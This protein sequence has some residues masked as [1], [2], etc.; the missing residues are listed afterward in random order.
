MRDARLALGRL[1]ALRK[2][3]DEAQMWFTRAR[4]VLDEAG[5][6]PLRAIVDH[7]EG[8]MYLRRAEAGD[9]QRGRGLLDAAI[10]QFQDL[11]MS[12]WLRCAKEATA[13]S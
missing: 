4:A 2:Q 6:L 13:Q 10:A 7:D 5:H 11:S 12:G 3:Y 9:S 8:L 1:C